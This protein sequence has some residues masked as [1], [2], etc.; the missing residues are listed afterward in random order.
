MIDFTAIG[1]KI[2]MYRKKRGKTQA[3]LAENLDVSSK[4]ISAIER[5]EAKV[6]L[7]RLDEIAEILN[8]SIT[9]L[10]TG[11]DK[12]SSSYGESEILELTSKWTSKEKSLLIEVINTINKNRQI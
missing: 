6:S 11:A 8:V 10:L 4:Y 12:N 7:K 1:R 9:D 5:G 2:K 3:D